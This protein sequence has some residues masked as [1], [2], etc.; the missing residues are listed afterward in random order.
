MVV[1]GHP[2]HRAKLVQELVASTD[3]R[4]KLFVL[5]GSSP[6]LNPDEW[7]RKN[8][9]HD[10]VGRTSVTVP[11]QFKAEAISVLPLQKMPALVGAFFSDP[12]LRYITA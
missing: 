9:K 6:Q 7:V 2:T 12:G 3:R 5:P 10:R 11:E 4:L 8:V 1:D